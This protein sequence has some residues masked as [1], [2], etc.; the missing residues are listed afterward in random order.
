MEN[1]IGAK[2]E[3]WGIPLIS[4]A[5]LDTKSPIFTEKD[6]FQG[7]TETDLELSFWCLCIFPNGTTGQYGQLCQR[8]RL[9]I[10]YCKAWRGQDKF[11]Y[12]YIFYIT[13]IGFVWMKKVI[14]YTPRMLWGWVYHP[15][16]FYCLIFKTFITLYHFNTFSKSL[17]ER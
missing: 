17:G 13:P 5:V 1:N 6:V 15:W 12:N 8:Q 16:C 11:L 14:Q 3:P 7:K 4:E 2:M 9:T 10:H